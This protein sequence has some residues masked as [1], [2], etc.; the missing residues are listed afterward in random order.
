MFPEF[1]SAICNSITLIQ[2][3]PSHLQNNKIL[4]IGVKTHR[5]QQH[6]VVL[7]GILK[8]QNNTAIK[9]GKLDGAPHSNI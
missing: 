3:N 9:L 6:S 2:N 7:Q 8:H 5:A 4:F 1:F